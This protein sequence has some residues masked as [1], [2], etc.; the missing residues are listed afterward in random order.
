MN[1]PEDPWH[2]DVSQPWIAPLTLSSIPGNTARLCDLV[3]P[4]IAQQFL[5]TGRPV[6]LPLP[7]VVTTRLTSPRRP[8]FRPKGR[9][10]QSWIVSMTDASMGACTD[11][12]T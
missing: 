10:S 2:F 1:M 5:S 6:Q 8:L 11:T 9:L 12:V 7:C 3:V 4:H